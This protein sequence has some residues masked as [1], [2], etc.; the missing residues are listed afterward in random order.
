MCL[1]V[2]ETVFVVP[3]F[4]VKAETTSRCPDKQSL[5]GITFV[6]SGATDRIQTI[7]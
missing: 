7:G 5:Q 2:G 1:A 6:K 3:P 4:H